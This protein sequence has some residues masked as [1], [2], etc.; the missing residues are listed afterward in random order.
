MH[1]IRKKSFHF[2]CGLLAFGFLASCTAP[3]NV[4]KALDEQILHFGLGAEPQHLDPHLATSVAAHNILS[5][6]LEGLVGEDPKTL[7]PVPGAAESWKISE[8]KKT[9]TFYLRKNAKWHN[10]DPVTAQDFVYSYRR[11]L[12][13]SL[14]AQYA[15]ML[16]VLK[17]AKSYHSGE[18][19]WKEANVGVQAIDERTLELVLENQTP[20]FLELLNHYSWFPVHPP[21]IEK[22]GAAEKM[23]TPWTKPGN[24]VGNGPF[25][26]R[27]HRI[28]SVI[29][30][31]ANPHYWDANLTQ[32]SGIR[33]Y[34]IETADTEE[35][36]FR[37]GFLHV[38]Q[39]VSSDRIEYLQNKHPE[40]IHFEPYLGTYYYRF[41]VKAPPFDDLRVRKALSLS[42]NRK[43]LVEKVLKG[44]QLPAYCFTPPDTGGFTASD[45][46]GYDPEQAKNLLNAYL[47]DHGLTKLPP[48][49]LN[50]NTSEGHKKV[51]EALQA[52][53]KKALGIEIQLLNME[54]KVFLSTISKGDYSLARAGWIGD[55]VDAN[56]FLH[57]WRS[58]DGNNLT[59]WSNKEYDQALTQAERALNPKDRFTHF[60]KCEE[61]LAS[62]MPILPLYFYV[63]VS[64]RHPSVQGW[65]PTLLDHHPYKYVYLKGE[66]AK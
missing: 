16:H 1:F 13:P 19:T 28:N 15:S 11:I 48:I 41:N 47:K 20:Y 8:D 4:E 29:E 23:G 65:H 62:E 51:A 25:S 6:L 52:M 5:A 53:W 64:L 66:V 54:W 45:G 32:L 14:G 21:T 40:W 9:Y 63:H 22:F 61:L 36:A 33:F 37:T 10:G 34:P 17:N 12:T 7:K 57:L 30:V 38:T 24:F 27:E 42:V 31:R 46:F 3:S 39:S 35:R 49:E 2:A 56:T 58:G 18:K 44:G 60:Q 26:L 43:L 59:G 50:Y 55:Y